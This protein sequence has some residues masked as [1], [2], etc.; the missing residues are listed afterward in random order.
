L[1]LVDINGIGNMTLM[2][3]LMVCNMLK[4]KVNMTHGRRLMKDATMV[5]LRESR[6]AL[7]ELV[8]VPT[9]LEIPDIRLRDPGNTTIKLHCKASVV[10]LNTILGLL[11]MILRKLQLSR[12]VLTLMDVQHQDHGITSKDTM[13]GHHQLFL[14]Q[15]QTL[16]VMMQMMM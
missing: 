10:W 2:S 8:S 16:L 15:I 13:P 11:E 4:S 5:R 14:R 6:A 1:E 3:H 12:T 7:M 9:V